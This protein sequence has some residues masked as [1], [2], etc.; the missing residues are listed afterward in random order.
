MTDAQTNLPEIGTQRFP[1]VKRYDEEE[2]KQVLLNPKQRML[3]VDTQ[4]LAQQVNEKK[5]A[6]EKQDADDAYH[7]QLLGHYSQKM[8][9]LEQE[10]QQL[11]KQMDR[12]TA[13]F[14]QTY[15]GRDKALEH[16]VNEPEDLKKSL[17]ARTSDD[18][19][20][21]TV[22]SMQMF[23]G[24]D[25]HEPERRKQQNAEL[26]A[27]LQQ[28]VEDH[29]QR[30]HEEEREEEYFKQL[31]A[32]QDSVASEHIAEEQRLRAQIAHETARE[33][34]ELAQEKKA[35]L[36]ALKEEDAAASEQ[37]KAYWQQ[38]RLLREDESM[39]TE[40]TTTS[41][42]RPDHLKKLPDATKNHINEVWKTQL[43]EAKNKRRAEREEAKRQRQ[44]EEYL[45]AELQRRQA[46]V[47]ELRQQRRREIANEQ[48]R[49]REEHEQIERQRNAEYTTNIP[50]ERFFED[51]GRYAR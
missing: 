2:R 28:Q 21:C 37:E 43:Q 44:Y 50:D 10:K 13:E 7:N 34:V 38:H 19:P 9:E 51:F 46:E 39:A 32:Y 15:Q 31:Q 36:D 41:R 11:R 24:E 22:S 8:E 27:W 26:T 23:A 14:Q 47:E 45:Q 6:K 1:R 16:D 4:A 30:K 3:G 49:Q 48:L 42:V 18:D 35:Q 17:P 12:D 20:R 25:L 33:N 5:A 29:Q 40:G